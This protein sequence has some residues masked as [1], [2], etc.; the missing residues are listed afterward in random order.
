[1][2]YKYLE[3]VE[4]IKS[5]LAHQTQ[6]EHKKTA[7]N[8]HIIKIQLSDALESK[9]I[10][11]DLYN[12]TL[13]SMVYQELC[14]GFVLDAMETLNSIDKSYLKS[15]MPRQLEHDKLLMTEMTFIGSFLDKIILYLGHID[16][17]APE[18]TFS[19]QRTKTKTYC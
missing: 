17:N 4:I 18:A 3:S 10:N 19:V 5:K 7:Y 12:R 9:E 13:V 16:Q 14:Q 1:M 2:S 6:E 15:L 8:N 11:E